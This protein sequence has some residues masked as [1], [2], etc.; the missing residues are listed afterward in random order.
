MLRGSIS[1]RIDDKGRLKVPS[2]FRSAVTAQYGDVLYV[3]SLTGQSVLIYP[4]PVWSALEE[5]LREVPGTLP[6]RQRYIDRV[7]FY[8]QEA[9]F[10]QQGRVSIHGHLREATEMVGET[11]VF[12][13][14]D[15]LEVWNQERFTKKLTQEPLTDDDLSALADFGI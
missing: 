4:M 14:L 9:T 2:V 13:K 10:D 5:R 12:G 6:A 7:S 8:G 1:A 15:H 3:T 11:R